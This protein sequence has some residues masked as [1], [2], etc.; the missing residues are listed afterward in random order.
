LLLE[1][2]DTTNFFLRPSYFFRLD[3]S[4]RFGGRTD[5]SFALSLRD[6]ESGD[7]IR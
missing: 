6:D 2:R 5:P 4:F 3:G 1:A 7:K